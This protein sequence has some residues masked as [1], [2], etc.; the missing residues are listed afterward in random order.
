MRALTGIAAGVSVAVA[1]MA[2]AGTIPA[3]SASAAPSPSTPANSTE[4][5]GVR[6]FDVPVSERGNERALRYIVDYLPVGSVI[7]RR[8]LIENQQ[9]VV[10]HLTV[11]PDAA[12]ISNGEFIGDAGQ[13]RSEL[14]TWISVA[15][16]VL[17]LAAHQQVTDMVTIKV[18]P[19]ATRGEQYAVIW[20]QE[21]AP[22]HVGTGFTILE[23]DRVG[24]RV[25]LA[26]GRGGAPPTS[27]RITSVTGTRMRDG[28]P[29]IV[30]H[31]DNTGGRAVDLSGTAAL[32]GG[33]GGSNAGP[34]SERAIITLA[35]GQ[36]GNV[37]FAASK[38]LDNGPWTAKVS[39]VSGLTSA[40]LS[41]TISF[42][43][44]AVTAAFPS[45]AAI[46]LGVPVAAV[47]V[48]VGLGWWV[49]RRRRTLACHNSPS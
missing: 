18:P 14:T 47:L 24:I 41:A 16:P 8:I 13:T 27:F 12:T 17:T 48:A 39:L 43:V 22:A 2:M 31:V 23:V 38:G 35:P 3:M 11:Y 6:L 49:V 19:G 45:S 4:H 9:P 33:P 29:E 21:A 36:A 34:Y 28:T 26:V 10:A 5:F 25:Y 15:K 20:A 30:A 37:A 44:T 7:Q 46:Y 1:V 32:T 42:G 40:D